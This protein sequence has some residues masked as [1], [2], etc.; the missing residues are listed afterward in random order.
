MKKSRFRP[1]QSSDW[2]AIRF[3]AFGDGASIPG[4]QRV[5]GRSGNPLYATQGPDTCETLLH[6][7]HTQLTTAYPGVRVARYYARLPYW[8]GP[9]TP[10][11]DDYQ[12]L[13]APE[14]LTTTAITVLMVPM[15][16]LHDARLGYSFQNNT[17][18]TLRERMET[19]TF[20]GLVGNLGYYMTSDLIDGSS[21]Y[22]H[23][24]RYPAFPLPHLSSYIGFYWVKN[25][26]T[27]AIQSTF[28]GAH[29]SAVALRA[30][31][32]IR[33]LP[34]IEIDTY[35]VRLGAHTF[36]VD[37][38]NDP[39]ALAADVV[40]FTPG[41]QTD[42]VKHYSAAAEES[43]GSDRTWQT[44]APMIPLADSDGRVHVFLANRG[45]GNMPREHVV[46]VWS[47]I[48]PLPSFGTVLSFKRAYFEHLFESV[49]NFEQNVLNQ[50]IQITPGGDFEPY[51]QIMGG[52]V[53]VVVDGQPLYVVDTLGEVMANLSRYGNANS[54]IAQ[55]GRE[56]ENFHPMRREPAGILFQTQHT[57][58][59]VLFDG[60][61]ELSIGASVVDM[62]VLLKKLAVRDEFKA[63]PIQQAILID[64]GSAMKAYHVQSQPPTV[65]LDLLNRVA[66]GARNGPNHDP[67]GLN[68]YASL[69]LQL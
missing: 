24:V 16:S 40:A 31:G 20:Q 66:A 5:D 35:P 65:H 4:F 50:P 42:T 57:I 26:Q 33:I 61:H 23:N 62:A 32:R 1:M 55:L 11:L 25:A 46:A 29:P 28:Q 60:R 58:G 43:A 56:T 38:I 64:G 15:A 12:W 8:D 69:M 27:G 18:P 6:D 53:P 36:T 39:Q 7:A 63:D 14:P 21:A 2:T 47:G 9:L 34:R 44:Y 52:F 54:P 41:V 59:W 67:E 49:E 68:L 37:T 48:A 51:T 17:L 22:A 30:D 19:T 10:T 45:D 13:D 3:P